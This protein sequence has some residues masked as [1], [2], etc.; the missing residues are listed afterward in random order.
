MSL[1]ILLCKLV[2][3]TSINVCIT[4]SLPHSIVITFLGQYWRTLVD[5]HAGFVYILCPFCLR[6]KQ[7]ESYWV[8]MQFKE[9]TR[10]LYKPPRTSTAQHRP[11]NECQTKT[12]IFRQAQKIKV[13]KRDTSTTEIILETT[14]CRS[15]EPA[16]LYRSSFLG[17]ER[18]LL[19]HQYH[20]SVFLNHR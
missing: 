8:I 19:Y 12:T 1:L 18:E 2:T 10:H 16:P 20:N 5:L 3:Y 14:A 7:S 13:C 6:G 15:R 4:H 11:P 17:R 9:T